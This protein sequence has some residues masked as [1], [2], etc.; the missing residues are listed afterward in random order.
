MDIV[1]EIRK[2]LSDNINEKNQLG[3]QNFFREGVK[4]YGVTSQIV[5]EII[6]ET[7]KTIKNKPKKEIFIIC[8]ELWKS[9]Y[10]EECGIASELTYNMRKY[11]EIKDF[12]LFEH[13]I[14]RYVHNWAN[15]DTFC[16]HSMGCL[17]EKYPELI[18]EIKS[19][20]TQSDNRWKKRASAVT[21]IIPAKN[22]LFFNDIIDIANRLLLDKDD[23]VQKGYGWML[24]AAS[25]SYPDEIYNYLKTKK[26]IMPRTSFRYALEKLPKNWRDELMGKR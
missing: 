25:Q 24:K 9:G 26:E 11:Y 14:D 12:E 18:E 7:L 16:N 15:C 3:A 13:W 23:M 10:L 5:K 6:K 21:F 2:K 22:G 17:V 19:R 1:E 4:N 20:W 8:E